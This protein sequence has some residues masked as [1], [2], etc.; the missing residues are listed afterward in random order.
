MGVLDDILYQLIPGQNVNAASRN[1]TRT[2]TGLQPAQLSPD[3]FSQYNYD[4]NANA[5]SRMNDVAQTIADQR[6]YADQ[7]YSMAQAQ[8]AQDALMRRLQAA[9]AAA[10]N[11]NNNAPQIPT[12][13]R[14]PNLTGHIHLPTISPNGNGGVRPPVVAPPSPY[15]NGMNGQWNRWAGW[16]DLYGGPHTTPQTHLRNG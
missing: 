5:Y 14:N 11:N 8:K 2:T 7:R 13:F 6:A 16:N 10:R 4:P 3:A 12:G 1:N 9:Q 15:S